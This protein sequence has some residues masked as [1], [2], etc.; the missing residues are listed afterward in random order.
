[1]ERSDLDRLAAVLDP[2]TTAPDVLTDL[3]RHRDGRMR[4]LGLVCLAD[5]IAAGRDDGPEAR[6]GYAKALPGA[7][8]KSPEAALA[9]AR[10][11]RF[12]GVKAV[13][14][15]RAADLPSRVRIAWL[16]AEICARPESLR[17]EPL[18][19]LLY[20]A[21]Q[22]I[23]APEDSERLVQELAARGDAV[24]RGEAVRLVRQALYAGRLAP[25]RARALLTDLAEDAGALREL[26]EPWAALDPLPHETVRRF[27]SAGPADA[28]IEVA[29][30]HGHEEL[31]EETAADRALPP[32]TRRRALEALGGLAV[33]EDVPRI[34][35]SASEDPLLLA[36]PA[37]ACLLGLHRRG[38]FPA[39]GDVPA[40]VGLAL[41]D[42]EVP[43]DDVAALLFT[44]RH[45]L[46]HE[47]TAG[48]SA[49]A[50]LS[51]RLE[52]LVALAAQGTGDLP[53]GEAVTGLLADAADPVP[54][55]RAIRRLRHL[56]A[57][58][59]VI[60]ALPR[61]PA[62]ALDAL[63]AVGG[64][65]TAA[66]LHDALGLGG[67]DGIA[68]Y[69]RPVRHTALALLWH[70]TEEDS[71][72]RAIL[73][74]LDPHDLP[75]RIAA[76][77]GGPDR[78][79]LALLRAGL[80]PDDPVKALCRL[81]RNGDATTVPVLADLLLRV[82]SDLA[83]S[84]A[85]DAPDGPGAEP[86]VPP[87]AV[88]ALSDLG[89][90]LHGR[91]KIRPR[92]LLDVEHAADAGPALVADIAL[93]LLERPDLSPAEQMVLLGMPLRTPHVPVR[94]RLHPLL[95]HRERHVRKRV[96]AVLA[97]ETDARVLSASLV[98]LTAAPD[99]QTVRQ[100]LLALARA[101]AVWAAEA[102]AA[103]LDHP[104][105]NVKKTAAAALADAGAPAAVPKLL[106]WLGS[107]GNPGLRDEITGAL[108]AILGEAFAATVTAAADRAADQRTRDNLLSALRTPAG[109]ALASDRDVKAL[110]ERG[111]D[112]ET[113]RR[114]ASG[115]DPDRRHDGLRPMLARWLELAAGDPVVLRFVLRF[116]AP[117]WSEDELAA[118]AR[119]ARTLVAA[120]PEVA[121]DD[122]G[123]LLA[124]L[125]Q[126]LPK[127]SAAEAFT[128]HADLRALPETV[129]AHLPLLLLRRTG[130]VLTRADLDRALAVAGRGPDPWRVEEKVLREAF[131]VS[132]DEDQER[133]RAR[134]NELIGEFPSADTA[135]RE[136]LL[137]QMTELQPIGAPP[138]TLAE[139]AH[140]S[141]TAQRTHKPS[142]LDQ[143]RSAAQRE[144]LLAMLDD[145]APSRREAA[146]H[147]L[148]GWPEPEIRSTVLRAFLHGRIDIPVV[149]ALAPSL[150]AMDEQDL[151][152]DLARTARVAAHL[153][154]PVL[155]RFIP[156]LLEAWEA[157]GAEAGRALR[158]VDPDTLAAALADRL[159]GGAWG[160]LDLL[161]GRTLLST[162]SLRKACSRLRAEGRAD[163]ADC[164][165]LVEGPLRRPNAPR[166]E[167][168]ALAS[169]RTRAATASRHEPSR[170]EL[171]RLAR[172][173]GT[174]QVR[175]A[176]SR[177]AEGYADAPEG[178]PARDPDFEELLVDSI[179]HPETRVRL[180]AHRIAR[181]AL[182]RDA[183]LEQT[184]R[185][186]DNPK[187][188]LVRSAVRTL[189]RASWEP[190]VPALV[191]LLGHA[192]PLVRREAAAGLAAFGTAA[193]PALRR[194]AG[195]ARPD[196][197]PRYTA[198]IERI[199]A[200]RD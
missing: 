195:R 186:L 93:D 116:C 44:C 159:D 124:V 100:A 110:V 76:D 158:G 152:A 69:L 20:R 174:E 130:A 138:W 10:L 163:I 133:S 122:R 74:R 134:L 128:I 38:H 52:L 55:L 198:L 108:R 80:D 81:A 23:D 154:S 6:A 72:R 191:G 140:R 48:S 190:A 66:V 9:Q 11:H 13:P 155:D 141:D 97:E 29:A 153:R 107:H 61:S 43:A 148:L 95:R 63:E 185:L 181:K 115:H 19:D 104:N 86:E 176:L 47:L 25:G 106:G 192:D 167:D 49:D 22:D 18:G 194:A 145:P 160:L 98:P 35:A 199:T 197:R 117:G 51:R 36:G 131:A 17:D 39:A 149:S 78:R 92:C 147:A 4:R 123:R 113:A 64:A 54:V 28:A 5:R 111:W 135:A 168:A 144:R 151:R 101:R 136:R 175:R 102:I 164:V 169:L 77:L 12:L 119:S 3:L 15:W 118:F 121:G 142:D 146:A 183:Y 71:G 156:L 91:A 173:G 70:L 172:T 178:P 99:V 188:D 193:L 82:V 200:D 120:L 161:E 177:L 7:L 85:G 127:L 59:A 34:A 150:T 96:I 75:E 68:S 50:D 31:L 129:E 32:R 139:Q 157:G 45:E 24:L 143:P 40:V 125:E 187:P 94:A 8:D 65:R 79:E 184:A 162:P 196:R 53:V 170:A 16:G 60:A 189:S 126:A 58:E 83:A 103:C 89:R 41:A 171:F 14:D 166:Q 46:L 1:M 26:A 67:A 56:P 33:R 114:I 42:H 27:L 165:T 182:D 112:D 88:A 180:H 179:G 105:M 90:R 109:W 84:W 30:R 62:A 132:A 87:E 21:V 57:E 2:R 137:A 37:V 73:D